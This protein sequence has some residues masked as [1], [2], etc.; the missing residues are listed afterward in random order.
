MYFYYICKFIELYIKMSYM[1]ATEMLSSLS[2][3]NKI[4][5]FEKTSTILYR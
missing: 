1:S 3:A 2:L 4:P 5:E